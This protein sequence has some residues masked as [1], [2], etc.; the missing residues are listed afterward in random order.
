MA[1]SPRGVWLRLVK[2]ASGVS[3]LREA[4]LELEETLHG[5]QEGEDKTEGGRMELEAKGWNFSPD[6]H[7]EIGRRCRRFFKDYGKSDGTIVAYLPPK[8]EQPQV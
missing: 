6:A 5:L 8:G 7:P 3:D 4:M 2:D 1:N